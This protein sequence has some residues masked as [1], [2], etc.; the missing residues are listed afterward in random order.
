MRNVMPLLLIP[1]GAILV[2]YGFGEFVMPLITDD[3]HKQNSWGIVSGYLSFTVFIGIA[4]KIRSWKK[5]ND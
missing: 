1:T 5:T 2:G 4:I 3:I